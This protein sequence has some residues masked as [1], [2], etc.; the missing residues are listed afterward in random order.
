MDKRGVRYFPKCIFPSGSFP[1][2]FSQMATSAIVT[3]K[4]TLGKCLWKFPISL[5]FILFYFTYEVLWSSSLDFSILFKFVTNFSQLITFFS[6]LFL[7]S[8]FSVNPSLIGRTFTRFA[9][10]INLFV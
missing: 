10:F 5:A 9:L 2:V 4:V 7:D 6:N 1:R 8:Q 3:W